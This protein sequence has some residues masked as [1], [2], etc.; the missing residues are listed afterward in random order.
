MKLDRPGIPCNVAAAAI[1]TV[2]RVQRDGAE[3]ADTD[4]RALLAEVRGNPGNTVRLQLEAITYLQ[5]EEPGD[6]PNANFMRFR[7]S[8][9]GRVAR[10]GRDIPFLRDHRAGD[11]LARGG[12]VLATELVDHDGAKAFRQSI[13]LVKPWAVEAALDGTLDRFS[14][15][16]SPVGEAACTICGTACEQFWGFVWMNCEHRP[17]QTYTFKNKDQEIS[18]LCEIE[19]SDAE[20]IETS[21]VA[22]PAVDGTEIEKIR[23]EMA[24]RASGSAPAQEETRMTSKIAA[25]LALAADASED[26]VL[27]KLGA[28]LEAHK[29][30]KHALGAAEARVKELEAQ[31]ADAARAQ[32]EKETDALI[33][34]AIAAGKIRPKHDDAGARVATELEKAIRNTASK[35]GLAAAKEYVDGLPSVIPVGKP[36]LALVTAEKGNPG[37]GAGSLSPTELSVAKQ[38]GVTPEEYLA[39]KQKLAAEGRG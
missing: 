18:A 28:E 33:E 35:L 23:A 22:V 1:G 3:L 13:E 12:T 4:R 17:G 26:Q 39:Q 10:T 20:L 16:W 7:A 19:F 37:V 9:L 11:M 25:L 14:I 21:G 6:R 29:A 31:L 38:M 27:A 5:G 2:L 36:S 32:L 15:G 34:G 30:T 24:R 8:K